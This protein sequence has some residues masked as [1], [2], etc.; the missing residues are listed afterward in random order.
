M[1]AQHDAVVAKLRPEYEK[2]IE[3]LRKL[4]PVGPWVVTA[5]IPDPPR[6]GRKTFTATF[7]ADDEA[8][9]R[10]WLEEQGTRLQ[11]NLYYTANPCREEMSEK[12]SKADIAAMS[13]LYVDIDP[14]PPPAGG[15]MAAHNAAERE[16]IRELTR[17]LPGEIPE[18]TFVVFSGGGYQAAWRLEEP[19]PLD[20]TAEQWTEAERYT[21]KLEE[22][23]RSDP[24]HNVERLLR[25]P[26]SINRPDARKRAKGRT[27][28]L[29]ELVEYEGGVH[30]ISLFAKAD[31]KKATARREVHRPAPSGVA[32]L[33][34]VD[35][36]PIPDLCKV[37]IAQGCDP[38]DPGR[39]TDTGP[40]SIS[41]GLAC[42]ANWT[43]DRSAVVWY[44][45][46][47]LVRA[48]VDDDTIR[49]VLLDPLW[50]V[51]SHVLDQS[52]PEVYADRQIEKARLAEADRA[53]LLSPGDPMRSATVYQRR[54]RP[55][56]V[57]RNGD[58][59]DFNGRCYEFVEQDEIDRDLWVFL[60]SAERLIGK[61]RLPFVVSGPSDVSKVAKALQA[62]SFRAERD[63]PP[64]WVAGGGPD[65][66]EIVVCENGL[67]H[68]PTGELRAH[69]PD[70]FTLNALD[71]PYEPD[72]GPPYQ[73]HEF[74]RQLWP[75][76]R[77][78]IDAL[79]EIFGYLLVP[80]TS[81]QKIFLI[82]GPPRS[83]K[84]TIGRVLE[85]LVGQRNYCSP[86]LTALGSDFGGQGLIGKQLAV[87]SD[88]RRG[89]GTNM[90]QAV[91]LL[92]RASGED[93]VSLNRKNKE[94]WQG[95][96]VVRFLILC[97]GVPD[98]R[99]DSGALANRFVPLRLTRSF[100]GREDPGLTDKLLAELPGILA[101][102]IEGW[103]RLQARGHFVPAP[104]GAE[105][106]VEMLRQG[107]PI[108]S[109]VDDCCVL[110]GDAWV[111]KVDLYGAYRSWCE[112]NGVR[113]PDTKDV[114]CRR[115][116]E[117]FGIKPARKR[118][119]RPDAVKT[120][121]MLGIQLLDEEVF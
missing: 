105:M 12:P 17:N 54:D 119:V 113:T 50:G 42:G 117:A 88:A 93:P 18:P 26:G 21:R 20:G 110:D 37:A 40:G 55:D 65:A 8:A 22:L 99:D 108:R 102:A 85:K 60:G 9:L 51:S 52:Q 106:V 32:S 98:F 80:D 115:L 44:V 38:E 116:K 24:C 16:R 3:F 33:A 86:G 30:D 45:V 5:I 95:T 120:P 81:Q 112:D 1:S 71:V 61:K 76:E 69:T 43:G 121:V 46:C 84:G 92:L 4:S 34:S 118:G 7:A 67:L 89:K 56:L 73:W 97:N 36:L 47:E 35:G 87:V 100:L 79:Q 58:W 13:W 96:L 6:R 111:P 41:R 11:R 66:R 29:A 31:P 19:V 72:V 101:W 114:M 15:D 63:E 53:P 68:L 103:R 14:T 70:L 10:E 74:L 23:L 109:F 59:L 49:A 75:D 48:E 27:E 25:L 57:W 107:S 82:E 104:S 78:S 77:E 64:C 28:A 62:L 91:E 90:G 39:W 83:G 2:S 94:F